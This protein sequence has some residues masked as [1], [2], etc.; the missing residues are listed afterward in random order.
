VLTW[1]VSLD[2]VLVTVDDQLSGPIVEGSAEAARPRSAGRL[3][4]PWGEVEHVHPLAV[5]GHGVVTRPR[6]ARK[7]SAAG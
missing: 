1:A 3:G 4:P 6:K 7:I 2:S 5:P